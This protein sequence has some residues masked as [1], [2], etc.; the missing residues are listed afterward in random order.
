MSQPTPLPQLSSIEVALESRSVPIS[1]GIGR[2]SNNLRISK[3]QSL[4]YTESFSYAAGPSVNISSIDLDALSVSDTSSIARPDHR[5]GLG[6]GVMSRLVVLS[7]PSGV[8]KST[9]IKRLFAEYPG[10]FRFSVSHTTRQPRA[11]EVNGNA[12]HFVQRQ[13][14]MDLVNKGGFIEW[15]EYNGNCYGT[16]VKAVEDCLEDPKVKCL[17]DIESEGVKSLKQHPQ[18]NP[19]LIFIAPPSVGDLRTRLGG[20]GTETDESLQARLDIALREIA[21]AKTGAFDYVVVNDTVDRAYAVL[22][23]LIV[24]GKAEADAL[25]EGL[26]AA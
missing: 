16:S 20:R 24:E 2:S 7:G 22:K 18:L 8:G 3:T 10:A 1:R 26:A 6:H 14:F 4:R 5:S 17:L 9:L 12:Y 25:P 19:L 15:T 13:G 11:G 23:G 21:Y